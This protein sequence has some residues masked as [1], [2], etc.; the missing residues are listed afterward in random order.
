MFPII[1]VVLFA[2]L[3][4]VMFVATNM[5]ANYQFTT[6]R[7][8]MN[9]KI[10][11]MVENGIYDT[12]SGYESSKGGYCSNSIDARDISAYRIQKCA[13]LDSFDVTLVASGDEKNGEDSYFTFLKK[14]SSR[15]EA[16]RLYVDNM[17]DFEIALYLE[18]KGFDNNYQIENE[19][20]T[21]M[22]K[23][24]PRYYKG[25]YFRATALSGEDSLGDKKDGG[26][27]VLIN[28]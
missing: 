4:L 15:P 28:G 24:L 13:K 3:L 18:C 26:V 20:T 12:S 10:A 22:K 9:E 11:L 23:R 27:K 14:H 7:M 8:N 25:T 19:F 2:L 17:D 6:D 1:I 21:Y 16:C 5:L